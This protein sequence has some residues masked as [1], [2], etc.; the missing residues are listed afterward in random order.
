MAF[1]LSSITRGKRLRAPKIVIYGPPK[2]GKSTFAAQAPKAIGIITEE[3]LDNLDV[4]A[5]PKATK[6]DEVNAALTTLSTEQHD[7]QTVFV[8]S[9]DWLEPLILA[10]VC[11]AHRVKNI[12]DIGYGKG[13]IMADDLW[14]DFFAALDYLRNERNMTVICIAHEQIN[15][16]R[17]PTLADDYD[18][19]SLKLNKRAVGIINEW[20]DIIG[21]A[22]HEVITRATDA[23]FNQK[24]IKAVSTGARKLHLNPHPA[25]IAGNRYG[26]P[27]VP[28]SWAAFSQAL[29]AAMTA[30][31][32][33]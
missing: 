22:N 20:A 24:D 19:Y 27:D 21:F 26:M 23:G 11:E 17:N 7:Y 31:S 4:D 2:V 29:T 25:Y 14:R 5:F 32:A 28:L 16:V 18:A 6:L 13:Y 1:D 10:K 8:D 33:A 3:G 30:P 12:E 15:K 9:L